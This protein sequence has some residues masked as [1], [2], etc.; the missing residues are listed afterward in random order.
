MYWIKTIDGY[1][2]ADAIIDVHINKYVPGKV[3]FLL[4]SGD[5][6]C[7]KNFE[8]DFEGARVALEEFMEHLIGKTDKDSFMKYV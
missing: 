3:M 6:V 4:S 8:N 1:V 7:Y 5:S 2:R